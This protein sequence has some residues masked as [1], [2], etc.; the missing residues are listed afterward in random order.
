MTVPTCFEM[1]NEGYRV[2]LLQGPPG[3]GKTTIAYRIC[4]EWTEGKLEMF[5]HVVVRLEDDRVATCKNVEEFIEFL[6]GN[7]EGIKVASEIRKIHGEGFLLILEGRDHL[8]PEQRHN[9]LFTDLVKGQ[10]FPKA[11]IAIT[12]HPSACVT[13]PYQFI[14]CR[15]QIFGFKKWQVDEYIKCSCKTHPDGVQVKQKK[16][17][18]NWLFFSVT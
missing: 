5:S 8:L 6:V 4:K 11:T 16:F 17:K 1:F 7:E 18:I 15:I 3:S 14:N 12:G 2:V 9:S 13:L 10:V